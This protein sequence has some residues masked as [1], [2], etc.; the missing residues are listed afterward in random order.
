MSYD[1]LIHCDDDKVA[2]DFIEIP[3]SS[4]ECGKMI[5]D[6][7]KNNIQLRTDF[8]DAV[9]K[10]R[11][12]FPTNLHQNKFMTGMAVEYI[13]AEFLC[14]QTKNNFVKLCERNEV[15]V[16]ISVFDRFRYSIKYSSPSKT[17][18]AQNVRLV[19]KRVVEAKKYDINED[20]FV[21]I[22]DAIT[23]DNDEYN[24]FNP[25]TKRFCSILTLAGRN[26]CLKYSTQTLFKAKKSQ[27]QGC[28][29]F[30]PADVIK[31]TDLNHTADGIDL[32]AEFINKYL[33][34]ENNSN[35]IVPLDIPLLNIQ[36]V[37]IIR[38]GLETLLKRKL[39]YC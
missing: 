21:V 26:L 14:Q 38:L 30:I 7:F 22:P 11:S 20:T 17:G 19:N 6:M 39:V 10:T 16:D 5:I 37:D 24:L 34:D 33:N 9:A 27:L 32:K 8:E 25:D 15:R 18:N 4:S 36:P 23:D 12:A 13:F 35:F 1:T 31:Q 28:I 3:T 2:P 29:V